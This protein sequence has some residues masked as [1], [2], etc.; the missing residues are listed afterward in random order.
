[1]AIERTTSIAKIEVISRGG[2]LACKI[3]RVVE[4]LILVSILNG[5]LDHVLIS[6]L[7]PTQEHRQMTNNQSRCN[8]QATWCKTWHDMR[9]VICN[10]YAC[11]GRKI[12]NQASTWQTKCA[13]GKMS[14]FRS[15]SIQRSP[16]SDARFANGKQNN[17]GTILWLTAR[18]HLKWN[19]KISYC[20]LT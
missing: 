3:L 20:T 8:A 11:S 14:S 17:N 7:Y 18:C 12:L 1:M 19:K 16:E 4:S 15:K 2:H 6:R 9:D 5:F 13:A 10:A